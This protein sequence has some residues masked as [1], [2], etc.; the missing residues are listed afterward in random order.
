MAYLR[1]HIARTPEK[2]FNTERLISLTEYQKRHCE[3]ADDLIGHDF[4]TAEGDK[5]DINSHLH[6]E[7][8][9]AEESEEI[10]QTG[11]SNN[12]LKTTEESAGLRVQK[13]VASAENSWTL[14]V[15]LN[16]KQRQDTSDKP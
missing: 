16:S 14:S 9:I 5:V 13:E 8:T 10:L 4:E 15:E 1:E 11:D 7:S 6:I 3:D 2:H 12:V